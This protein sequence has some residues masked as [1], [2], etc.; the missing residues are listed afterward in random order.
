MLHPTEDAIVVDTIGEQLDNEITS[1]KE[2]SRQLSL[3]AL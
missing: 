3:P 2:Q 1:L